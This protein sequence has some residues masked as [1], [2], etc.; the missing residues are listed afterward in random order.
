MHCK[1]G[2]ILN[3]MLAILSRGWERLP[4]AKDVIIG[5]MI[6]DMCLPNTYTATL[7]E[8]ARKRNN[9]REAKEIL[10]AGR[11]KW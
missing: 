8:L 11:R 3:S 5:A 4:V 9:E 7:L 2:T 6:C 1:V 10:C